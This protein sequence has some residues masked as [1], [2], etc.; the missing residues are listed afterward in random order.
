MQDFEGMYNV[1]DSGVKGVRNQAL[2][3]CRFRVQG[4]GVQG[5]RVWGRDFKV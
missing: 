3:F 1:Q 2:G 5:F 4:L